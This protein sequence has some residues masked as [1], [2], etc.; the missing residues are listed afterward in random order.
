MKS[1]ITL[2]TGIALSKQKGILFI[3][4][5]TAIGLNL[6]GQPKIN[7]Y[8]EAADNSVSDGLYIRSALIGS[9][10]AGKN[11]FEAGFE[12]NLINGNGIILTGY[13]I[14]A[15]RDFRIGKMQLNVKA[16]RLWTASSDILQQTNLGCT[17]SV[18]QKHFDLLMG[19]NFRTYR[20]RRKAFDELWIVENAGAIHENFN[21]MYSICYNI[22]SSYS[23]WNAG[24]TLTNVDYFLINQETNPF[25][26]LHGSF[27]IKPHVCLFAEAWYKNAGLFNISTNYF[28][29]AMRG[30]ITWKF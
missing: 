4:F 5:L 26:N 7:L 13:V 19:T 29:Y 16:F 9:Y 24:L 14:D 11:H 18:S 23:R 25:I 8:S 22:R 10:N 20:F 21:L 17:F 6:S 12:N 2:S 30:G 28:G 15:S 1:L 3:L 27:K